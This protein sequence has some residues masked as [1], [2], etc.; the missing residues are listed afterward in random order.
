MK[1]LI[2]PTG[3]M[4]GDMFAAGLV[5]A[6]ADFHLMQQAMLA[7]AEKLGA[8]EITLNK[9]EE[10]AAQLSIFLDSKR[11]HLAGSEARHIL[12]HLFEQFA[13]KNEYR[14]LGQR[15]LDILVKAEKQ[16]H[17]EFNI[18]I[19]GDHHHSQHHSHGH[20]HDHSHNHAH[21]HSHDHENNRSN[22]S[23]HS[24]PHTDYDE[25]FLHEAQDIVIDI[26]G[27]VVGMQ[28][29]NVEP[30]AALTGPISVGGG[31]VFCSH[32]KLNIPAPA[33]TVILREH[34]LPWQKGPL[35]RELLTPTGAAILAGLNCHVANPQDYLAKNNT[36]TGYARG[37]KILPIPPLELRLYSD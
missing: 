33:T 31:Y 36:I 35:E 25:T 8:A 32:G 21:D 27:A 1:L 7:A 28:L 19:Q 3:G 14:L 4:A 11:T 30:T 37:T 22:D 16:A 17:I 12:H 18:F 2:D 10:N 24:H 13:I 34:G 9:T 20:S 26:L 6:G 29:L 15:I 23:F 5:S